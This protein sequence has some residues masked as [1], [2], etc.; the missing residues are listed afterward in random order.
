MMEMSIK[1]HREYWSY[2]M[3]WNIKNTDTCFIKSQHN[4]SGS[5]SC[6]TPKYSMHHPSPCTHQRKRRPEQSDKHQKR[7]A[8]DIAIRAELT[9][10]YNIVLSMLYEFD[11]L[12]VSLHVQPITK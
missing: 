8:R 7:I 6:S 3:V 10:Y 9:L 2:W 4:H 11:G 12:S 1:S 5:V